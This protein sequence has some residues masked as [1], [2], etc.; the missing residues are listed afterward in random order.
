MYTGEPNGSGIYIKEVYNR[1]CQVLDEN[2]IEY[3]CYTYSGQ[4]LDNAKNIRL[5]KVPFA[6]KGFNR[7]LSLHRIWWN[8]FILPFLAQRYSCVYSFSNHGS[9]FIKKQVVTIHDLICMEFPSQNKL[10][11]LYNKYLLPSIMRNSTQIVAISAFT[12]QNLVNHFRLDSEKIKVIYNGGDHLQNKGKLYPLSAKVNLANITKNKPYFLCVGA[13]YPHKN[14]S[15]LVEAM[16]E[17]DDSVVLIITGPNNKYFRRLRQQ[18]EMKKIKNVI[19]LD[20]VNS[21][22]LAY[23]YANCLSNIYIS[24]HEGFG[25]PP[26]EAAGYSKVSLLS[27]RSALPEVYGDAAVY[28]DPHNVTAIC[29]ALRMM[30]SPAFDASLYTN[31]HME[32]FDRY[33]WSKTVSAVYQLLAGDAT[34]QSGKTTKSGSLSAFEPRFEDCV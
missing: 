21:D 3:T 7:L 4:G 1:L 16:R 23:L 12:K 20:Y 28:V 25:F 13:T 17:L 2:G 27:D 29:E 15:V 22:F 33:T 24:L 32:L 8:M 31:K 10:Q 6:K 30:A 11:Y 14:A 19:L 26:M 9:P 34:T 18:V 5:I